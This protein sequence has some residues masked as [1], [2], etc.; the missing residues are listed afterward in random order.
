MNK[1]KMFSLAALTTGFI[2]VLT[3]FIIPIVEFYSIQDKGSVGI[4]GGADSPTFLYIW[5][6]TQR[7]NL[8]F[9]LIFGATL[10]LCG[11]FCLIFNQ[12]VPKNCTLKTT[13]ISLAISFFGSAGLTCFVLWVSCVAFGLN[14]KE[15]PFRYP[16]S[17]VCGI[18]SLAAFIISIIFYIKARKNNLRIKGI[19]IDIL[20]SAIT[21]YPFF[22]SCC[23]IYDSL[24]KLVR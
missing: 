23:F 24:S 16:L 12:T 22:I 4:I 17:I 2:M 1:V 14:I 15:N 7:S 10:F 3:S 18:F 9:A 11:L 13:G 19:I 8:H 5:E 20:T 6:I 21:L